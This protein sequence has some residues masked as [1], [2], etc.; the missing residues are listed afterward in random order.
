MKIPQWLR[1][2][3]IPAG[4]ENGFYIVVGSIVVIFFAALVVNPTLQ[5]DKDSELCGPLTM[6]G[7]CYRMPASVCRKMWKQINDDCTWEVRKDIGAK[8][9]SLIG[10]PVKKCTKIRFDKAM[11]YTRKDER[12][13]PCNEYFDSLSKDRA[14]GSRY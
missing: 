1:A 13:A 6:E 12:D 9:T 11:Y 4:Y 14:P 2:I 3:K 5:Q 10:P 7:R 8:V